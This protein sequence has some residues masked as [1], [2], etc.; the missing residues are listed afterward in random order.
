MHSPTILIA[1]V[2]LETYV[3]ETAE[4]SIGDCVLKRISKDDRTNI[5]SNERV[6][7]I[8]VLAIGCGTEAQSPR[9]SIGQTV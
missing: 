8:V 4:N 2:P 6:T 5:A 9:D 7:L 3:V 1:R